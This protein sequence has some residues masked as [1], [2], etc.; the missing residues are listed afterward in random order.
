MGYDTYHLANESAAR[1]DNKGEN[2]LNITF[3]ISC[4]VASY[5]LGATN[6]SKMW[7]LEGR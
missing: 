1:C 2:A 4:V 3:K 6:E 5:K 7:S